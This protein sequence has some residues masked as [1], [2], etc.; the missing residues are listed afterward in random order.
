MRSISARPEQT[1]FPCADKASPA[2]RE[3]GPLESEREGLVCALAAAERSVRTF[4][5][6]SYE[7]ERSKAR[8]T[9]LQNELRAIK[10]RMSVAKRYGN[11]A[12]VIV[13]VVKE[14]ASEVEWG[15]LVAEAKRRRDAQGL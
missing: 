3:A 10:G 14:R 11:L 4:R 6:G 15:Q 1:P 5:A 2:S 9:R 12:D 13:E 7:H 8:V